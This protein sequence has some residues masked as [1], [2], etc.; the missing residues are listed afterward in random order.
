MKSSM[1]IGSLH[2]QVMFGS[3]VARIVHISGLPEAR[4]DL[5]QKMSWASATPTLPN[6]AGAELAFPIWTAPQRESMV[7]PHVAPAGDQMFSTHVSPT[8]VPFESTARRLA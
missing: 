5:V 3:G 2:F 1:R 7:D 8:I 4:T 6:I